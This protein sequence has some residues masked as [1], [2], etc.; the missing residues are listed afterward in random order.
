MVAGVT[1]KLYVVHGSHPCAAVERALTL[2]G[3]D[4]KRV[5]LP[6]SL[7]PPIQRLRFG[8]RTVPS[9]KFADGEKLSGSSAILRRLEEIAPDPPLFPADP[10]LRARVEEAEG[11]GESVF[12]PIARRLL[13]RGFSRAPRA[14]AGY[15]EGQRNPT[16][17]MP[18]I[19]AIAP[20]VT[21]IERRLNDA[22]PEATRA[23]LQALPG[24]LDRIDGWIAEGVL[25]GEAANAA[26]LQ[27]ATTLRLL[28]T[29]A[30]VRP[31]IAPRP[32]GELALRLF[33][34]H[35]GELP[36]GTLPAEWLPA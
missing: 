34:D 22:T 23:D 18:V 11:W 16:L 14:M 2:K 1:A 19:L 8:A 20:V 25:G 13:W 5:E 24:H 30:D 29:I 15:Q 4:H 31:L 7:H 35:P 33:P 17:P 21:R 26:D 10:S 12:Q 36:E 3:I 28:M 6:P 32:A 27:I 9:I